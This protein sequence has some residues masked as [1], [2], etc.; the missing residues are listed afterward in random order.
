MDSNRKKELIEAYKF[1]RPEMGVI[2]YHCKET[3]DVFLDTSKDTKAS[4]NSI[5]M[6]LSANWHPNKNLQELWN[7][8]GPEAFELSVIEVLKYD[9]PKGDYTR[10]LEDLIDRCLV[11]NPKA[12]RV[13]R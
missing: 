10:E 4:F 13:W 11:A 3:G 9:D 5:N 6:R 2:S 7:N 1:R 12:R 8:Y